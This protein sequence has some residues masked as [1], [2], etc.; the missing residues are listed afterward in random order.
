MKKIIITGAT[1]GIGRAIA[2]VFAAEGFGIAICAR[3][4]SDLEAL[5]ENFEAKYPD[6]QILMK[7]TDLRKKEEVIAFG[8]FVKSQWA[9]VDIL[10]NNA[11]LYLEGDTHNEADGI[12]E[13]LIETNLYSA[14]HLSRTILPMMIDKKQGHIFNICSIASFYAY[15]NAGSYSITKFALL[16]LSKVLREELKEKGVRV[17]AVL[18]G[19]TW[20][21]AWTGFEAPRDRLLDPKDVGKVILDA[22]RLSPNAVIEELIIRPQLGDL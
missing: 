6:C 3:T 18:P 4:L 8:D 17:T 9:E 19:I 22:W 1:K 5:K 15:P 2:E 16:G 13:K 10:V 12:L 21:D 11:G 20:S 7:S 14:Y